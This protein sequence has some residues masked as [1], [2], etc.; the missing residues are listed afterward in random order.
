MNPAAEK[1]ILKAYLSLIENVDAKTNMYKWLSRALLFVV[2]LG[3]YSLHVNYT[4]NFYS[5]DQL[6]LVT[7]FTSVFL[8]IGIYLSQAARQAKFLVKYLSKSEIVARINEI[9]T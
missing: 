6:A 7:M 3:V 4:E 5:K 8:V 9:N 1:K 2:V